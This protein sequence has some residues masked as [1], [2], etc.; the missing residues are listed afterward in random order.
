MERQS[1]IYQS[2]AHYVTDSE[3]NIDVSTMTSLGGSYEGVEPMGLIWFLEPLIKKSCQG[4]TEI[5]ADFDRQWTMH[6]YLLSGHVTP[7]DEDEPIS[8]Q[9][10]LPRQWC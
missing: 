2:Y 5:S 1:V 4:C 10:S 8:V 9:D 6:V 7:I 3:G